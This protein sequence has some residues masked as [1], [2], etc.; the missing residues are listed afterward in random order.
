MMGKEDVYTVNLY[1]KRKIMQLIFMRKV[2][3]FGFGLRY[4]IGCSHTGG[5]LCSSWGR[6]RVELQ[7][8]PGRCV[9]LPQEPFPVKTMMISV[10]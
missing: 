9:L 10:S 8:I 5:S 4:R 7:N 2:L 6:R 1:K 3:V